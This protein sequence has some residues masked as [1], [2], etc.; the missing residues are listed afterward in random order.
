MAR[1]WKENGIILLQIIPYLTGHIT[2]QKTKQRCW[3]Q[4]KF[5]PAESCPPRNLVLCCFLCRIRISVFGL[6]KFDLFEYFGQ[7]HLLETFG[8]LKFSRPK[9]GQGTFCRK[10]CFLEPC[11]SS[12]MAPCWHCEGQ[13]TKDHEA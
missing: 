10:A 3:N 11:F 13:R 12:T 7:I 1:S 8:F 5:G 9:D 6:R 2:R 4:S